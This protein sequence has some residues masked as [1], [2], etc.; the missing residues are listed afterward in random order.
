MTNFEAA[1]LTQTEAKCYIALLDV[2]EMKPSELARIVNESRTNCYKILDKLCEY[3]LVERFNKGKISHFRASNPTRL[4]ELARERRAAAEQAEQALEQEVHSLNQAYITKHEQP[5]VQH[6]TG[7]DGIAKI[8]ADQ[9]TVGRPIYFVNTLAGIDF[10]SYETMHQ[11]RMQAVKA[12]L[13]REAL[14]PDT[15]LINSDFVQTDA[16]YLLQRTWLRSQDYTAPIEWGAYGDKLYIIS[17]GTE[18]MGTVIENKNIA[19]SFRQ[20]FKIMKRGQRNQPWYDTLP[21]LKGSVSADAQ[22][23]NAEPARQDANGR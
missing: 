21:R 3:R 12:G 6:F 23:T 1:G 11:L 13:R 22:H 10:Y 19:E 18:A 17:F 14:T 4:L 15:P 20:L 7:P 9:I 2:A 5:G 8:Y 16:R